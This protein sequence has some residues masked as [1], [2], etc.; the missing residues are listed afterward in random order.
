MRVF[1]VALYR[2]GLPIALPRLR[3][4][5]HPPARVLYPVLSPHDVV[6]RRDACASTV[7]LLAV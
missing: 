5:Q 1:E 7:E 2:R 4:F 3:S 6:R